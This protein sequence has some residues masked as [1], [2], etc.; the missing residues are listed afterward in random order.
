MTE[1]ISSPVNQAKDQPDGGLQ[2]VA[3]L[4]A[5]AQ[6]SAPL[7]LSRWSA[8]CVVNVRMAGAKPDT[9]PPSTVGSTDPQPPAQYVLPIKL[10]ENGTSIGVG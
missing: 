9:G 6:P 5:D 3:K 7:Q 1:S 8:A 4:M 10:Q 2:R